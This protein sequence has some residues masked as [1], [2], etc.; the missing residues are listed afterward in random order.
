[1]ERLQ[2]YLAHAG[3]AS[4]RT[5]EELILAG[6][7]RVNG[8][9]VQEM[10]VKVN[11]AVDRVEV[12]GK[13]V[14]D[15]ED[16]VYVLL[17]KPRGY[18]T[19]LRDPQGRPKVVDLVKDVG[20]RVYPVGRLDYETEG[21]LLL[22][23]DGELT[24]ALTHP[25]HEIGKTYLALVKGVPDKDKLKRFQKGLR[26]ADGLTAPAKVRI[27]KKKGSNALMEIIIYE[28]RNRQI[29][30]MC[31]T[32]GHPVLELQ[33]QAMGFLELGS[34]KVGEFRHLT[35]T[36]VKKLKDLTKNVTEVKKI[37]GLTKKRG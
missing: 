1:M 37:K 6:K 22:T 15:K 35:V 24:F 25:S 11:P 33:R 32:I 8:V 14:E 27:A 23:N 12:G 17:N 20:R 26:L 18:V 19:T 7:V 10:G 13:P 21:L 16:K 9:V 30:R 2:K 4:R 3:I 29:R 36:E 31:E 28:G 34:L 5:C